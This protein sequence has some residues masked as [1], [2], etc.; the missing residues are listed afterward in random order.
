[1]YEWVIGL[2]KSG[3]MDVE[4]KKLQA[5]PKIK[6]RFTTYK[7]FNYNAVSYI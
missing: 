2:N 5:D 3:G 1:M 7:M 6:G 4:A